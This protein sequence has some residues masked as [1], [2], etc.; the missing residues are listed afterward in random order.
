MN[1]PESRNY[2]ILMTEKKDGRKTN[3]VSETWTTAS[4]IP[5]YTQWEFWERKEKLTTSGEKY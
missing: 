5:A 3:R 4:S 1:D 2:P